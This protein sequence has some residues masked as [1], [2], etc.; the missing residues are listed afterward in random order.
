MRHTECTQPDAERRS[1]QRMRANTVKSIAAA[2]TVVLCTATCAAR[3]SWQCPV[4]QVPAAC[5]CATSIDKNS[6]STQQSARTKILPDLERG[7]TG[8]LP[9]IV[10]ATGSYCEIY[11][12][13]GFLKCWTG[14]DSPVR[15][16]LVK[17]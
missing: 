8:D 5:R 16:S 3:Q 4:S 12:I 10:D 15:F 7:F 14:R 2:S 11:S 6:R 1:P 13:K 9:L 17:I